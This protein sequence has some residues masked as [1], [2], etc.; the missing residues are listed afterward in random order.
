MRK[1]DKSLTLRLEKQHKTKEMKKIICCLLL[2]MVLIS[3]DGLM[4]KLTPRAEGEVRVGDIIMVDGEMGVVFAATSDGKHGKVM[5][6]SQTKCNWYEAR[7][8]CADYGYGWRLPST[9]ELKVI[10]NNRSL[11]N[12]ALDDGGYA[13]LGK[14]FYWAIKEEDEECA[15]LVRM[16]DGFT[17]IDYK[18]FGH[19]VRAVSAF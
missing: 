18:C 13:E 9:D 14:D 5:S 19:Y 15:G 12:S 1:Q 4:R 7:S 8:W 17:T 6:T 10:C 16:D 11:L 2:A 3:C